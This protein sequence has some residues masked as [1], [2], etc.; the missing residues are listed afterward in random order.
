MK[1]TT[2]LVK[3]FSGVNVLAPKPSDMSAK[4][5]NYMTKYKR[6]PSLKKFKDNL[7]QNNT[8]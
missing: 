4:N 8:V 7:K 3:W 1:T 2:G 5:C 6:V